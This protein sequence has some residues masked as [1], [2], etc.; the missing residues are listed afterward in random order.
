MKLFRKIFNQPQDLSDLLQHG[1]LETQ[2]LEH[3]IRAGDVLQIR[4]QADDKDNQFISKI[5]DKRQVLDFIMK[6]HIKVM[7]FYKKNWLERLSKLIMTDASE[8]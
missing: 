4:V 1:Q 7:Q 5:R 8:S 3:E 6:I 2:Y